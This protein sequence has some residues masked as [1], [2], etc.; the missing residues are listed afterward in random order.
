MEAVAQIIPL[1]LIVA[2]FWL[3]VVRPARK[4]QHDMK[5]LRASIEVG[6]TVLLGSG[7]Y[8]EIRAITD[9]DLRLEIASGVVVRVHRDAVVS[10]DERAA[11]ADDSDSGPA[12]SSDSDR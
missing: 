9:G 5:K 6:D 4:K 3:L 1:V 11:A 8:G 7:M 10:V 12:A 2:V